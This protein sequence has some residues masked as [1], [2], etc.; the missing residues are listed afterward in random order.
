MREMG[1]PAGR[2]KREKILLAEVM[3]S[4]SAIAWVEATQHAIKPI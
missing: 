1:H 4:L 2:L 3:S